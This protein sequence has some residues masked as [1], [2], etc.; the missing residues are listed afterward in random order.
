M[1]P[2]SRDSAEHIAHDEMASLRAGRPAYASSMERWSLWARLGLAALVA[3]AGFSAG[4]GTAAAIAHAM[5]SSR[6]LVTLALG[7]V[8]VTVI[9]M[10]TFAALG[11]LLAP[12]TTGH[13]PSPPRRSAG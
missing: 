1:A 10:V 2:P 13:D 7:A 5:E 3:V 11:R 6:S 8:V 12:R 4:V 9:A